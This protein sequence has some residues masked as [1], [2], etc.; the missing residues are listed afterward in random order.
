MKGPRIS[1]PPRAQ[2]VRARHAPPGSIGFLSARIPKIRSF[3][4]HQQE[5]GEQGI[6][7]QVLMM[8]KG[9]TTLNKEDK[10]K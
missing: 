2:A 1:E 10:R 3:P 4:E 6:V 5:Q 8:F 9:K 7:S